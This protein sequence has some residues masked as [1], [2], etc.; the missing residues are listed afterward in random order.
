[1]SQKMSKKNNSN[2]SDETVELLKTCVIKLLDRVN[3]LERQVKQLDREM[4]PT[5]EEQRDAFWEVLQDFKQRQRYHSASSDKA[6]S[7][8]EQC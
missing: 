3:R 8:K 7:E 1:M 2:D 5:F 4:H 6:Q